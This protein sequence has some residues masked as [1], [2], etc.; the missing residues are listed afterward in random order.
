MKKKIVS[1]IFLSTALL[2]TLLILDNFLEYNFLYHY[3]ATGLF[4]V[5]YTIQQLLIFNIGTTPSSFVIIYNV[6]TMLKMF[7][8]LLFLAGYYLFLS[9]DISQNQKNQFI[10]FFILTYFCYLIVNTKNFFSVQN[11]NT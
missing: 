1:N 6:T 5:T 10:V 4:L 9:E 8:S 11:E 7:M 2:G 3:I